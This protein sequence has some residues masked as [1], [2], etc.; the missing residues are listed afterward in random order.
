[1]GLQLIFCVETT[2][3]NKSD[4]IYIRETIYQFYTPNPAHVKIT[5]VYM[6]GKGN[7]ASSRTLRKIKEYI[8][9]YPG[10]TIVIYCIDCDDFDTRPEDASFLRIMKRYCTKFQYEFVWFCKDIEHVF[11]GERISQN[12]KKKSAESFAAKGRIQQIDK[13]S[14]TAESYL[15]KR[16]NLCSILDKYLQ[17]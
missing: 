9:Q 12:A 15:M 6:D 5:P 16:S 13:K 14:L 4:Y 2:K 10:E 17:E 11:L 1:M 8:N 7:Y 3:E